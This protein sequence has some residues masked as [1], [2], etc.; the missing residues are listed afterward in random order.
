MNDYQLSL[1][2]NVDSFFRRLWETFKYYVVSKT[3]RL[4]LHNIHCEECWK[5]IPVYTKV[6]IL[7]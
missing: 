2:L 1:V 7:R 3:E 6:E 4:N 5:Y